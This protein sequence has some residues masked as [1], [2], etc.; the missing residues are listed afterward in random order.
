ME[1]IPHSWPATDTA[2]MCTA[3][4]QGSLELLTRGILH[5]FQRVLF[6]QLFKQ[7]ESSFDEPHCVLSPFPLIVFCP[8]P[9]VAAWGQGPAPFRQG[10]R[11]SLRHLLSLRL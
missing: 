4:P 7:L 2:Q 5:V 6:S 3:E 10:V 1:Q 11:V 9:L 8:I